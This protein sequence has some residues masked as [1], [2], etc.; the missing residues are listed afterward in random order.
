MTKSEIIVGI[1]LGTTN[2]CVAFVDGGTGTPVVIPNR[3]GYRTTPSVVAMTDS[4]RRLVGHLAKRQAVVN[5]ENTAF[6]VKR[7][8]GRRF[9]SPVVQAAMGNLPYQIVE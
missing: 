7:F 8:I 5:A 6:A 2:S 3:G 1:D 4:G 9:D